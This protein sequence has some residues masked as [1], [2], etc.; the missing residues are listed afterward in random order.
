MRWVGIF[1]LLASPA[2]ADPALISFQFAQESIFVTGPDIEQVELTTDQN[3]KAALR[4]RL[5]QGFDARFANISE[6]NIG[7]T[8]TIRI[9]GEVVLEPVLQTPLH[10]A[11]FVITTVT[12]EE[13]NRLSSVLKTKTCPDQPIG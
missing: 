9:C 7:E 3:G 1:L 11:A 6:E 4:V 12:L 5:H 8:L 10:R 13:A 2:I